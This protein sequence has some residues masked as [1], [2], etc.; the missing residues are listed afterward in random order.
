[1]R[2]CLFLLVLFH[3]LRAFG[4]G[5]NCGLASNVSPGTYTAMAITGSGASQPGATGSNWYRFTPTTNGNLSIN[6]CGGG[7][8]T[9]LWIWTGSCG[10]LTLI[11]A[12]D[13]FNGCISSGTNSFASRVDNLILSAG[14]TYFFEWDNAWS[15]TGFTWNFSYTALPNNND[16]GISYLKNRFTKI[17]ISQANY[18]IPLGATIKNY[19]GNILSNVT[20]TVEIYEFPNINTPVQTLTSTPITLGI[21]AEQA[22]VSGTWLPNL[23]VSKNYMLKY[24]KTQTQVDGV[25]SNDA[26]TQ[27]LS[28]DFNSFARDN[29][30]YTNAFN[31]ST[32]SEYSQGVIFPLT[33][34]DVL[35]GIQFYTP[36]TSS[37]QEYYVEVFPVLNNIIQTN[38]IYVSQNILSTG[39]GWQTHV[40]STPLTLTSGIYLF[41]IH[42]TGN[43]P[44]P[45]GCDASIF[46]NGKN[47]VR[48]NISGTW[49]TI[50]SYS[51]NYAFMIRPKLGASPSIDVSYVNHQSPGAGL[52][53]VHTRQSVNGNNLVLTAFGKNSGTNNAYNVTMTVT[54]KNLATNNTIYTA[55]SAGHNLIA[56]QIDTF[57]VSN[58]T[59]HS[60]GNYSIEYV[61]NT[62]NDQIPLNNSYLTYFSRTKSELSRVVGNSGT[63]G[64]GNNLTS[65]YDNG[66]IGQN[67]TLGQSDYLDS[68]KIN[69]GA[70]TPSNQPIRVDIYATDVNG[71][72]TG[73]PLISTT[74]YTST[75][76]NNISG[77]TIQ[78]P[79]SGGTY[80]LNPGTY[81]FGVTENAGNIK[82]QT[83][84]TYFAANSA[85]MRWNQNP[86]GATAWTAI[87]NFGYQ[88]A[89]AIQPIFKT[90][91]PIQ[92][93]SIVTNASCGQN[94][95]S[96]Q[97]TAT[98]GT[99]LFTFNWSN[100]STNNGLINNLGPGNY[101]CQLYDANFCPVAQQNATITMTSTAVNT[102]VSTLINPICNGV[103]S[104]SIGIFASGGNGQ[105]SYAWTPNIGTTAN[106][107]NLSA[108]SYS[109]QVTDGL[110][111][112]STQQIILSQP[113]AINVQSTL[114]PISCFGGNNGSIILSPTGGTTP[115][116]FQWTSGLG[117]TN[118]VSNLN[119]GVYSC[120]ITDGNGCSLIQNVTISNPPAIT[121]TL[122]NVS[123]VACFGTSSGSAAI[124][125]A[126]GTG[127]LSFI[128]SPNS[129]TGSSINNVPAGT[130]S[131][132]ISDGNGCQHSTSLNI[133]QPSALSSVISSTNSVSCFGGTN[134]T[135]QVIGMGGTAPYSYSWSPS[136]GNTNF[137][138]NLSAGNYQCQVTDAN[139]CST[140][141]LVQ[142]TS[143]SALSVG[144][145]S[146]SP[147]TCGLN[148]GSAVVTASGGVGPYLYNWT[149]AVGT[150]SNLTNLFAGSYQVHVIDQ[151]G[152][153]SSLSIGINTISGPSV[154][155]VSQTPVSCY[156][157]ANGSALISATGGTGTLTYNWSGNPT[158]N[159]TNF[160]SNLT[161]AQYTCQVTDVNGCVGT[162]VV[163]ITQPTAV[164][165]SISSNTSVTCNGL[166]TG[167]MS[168]TAYGGTPGY[169]YSWSP[170][171]GN[172]NQLTNVPAGIYTCQIT[173]Q[174]GC[175]GSISGVISQPNNMQLF[176]DTTIS[177]S[178][179]SSTNGMISVHATGGN[180]LYSYV[181]S[182]NNSNS[183]TLIQLPMGS[184]LVTA[185]DIL[186]CSVSQSIILQSQ[187][188][189]QVQG[190]SVQ[191]NCFGNANGQI[192]LYP[193]N[194]IAP[195][196]FNWSN[197]ATTSVINDLSDGIYSCT[198]SDA[199]GCTTVYLDTITALSNLTAQG[200]GTNIVCDSASTGSIHVTAANGFPPYSYAWSNSTETS[201]TLQT[202]GPGNFEVIVTDGQNCHDTIS[203][204]INLSDL[205]ATSQ[206]VSIACPGGLTGN[207][208]VSA[209]GG[210]VP[211]LY[212]WS[213]FSWNDS[214]VSGIGAGNYSCT[215][216]DQMG[217]AYTLQNTVYEPFPWNINAVIEPEI[218]GLD[219]SIMLGVSGANPPYNYSWNNG[220]TGNVLSQIAGGTYI[221]T[222]TD[223]QGCQSIDS[224]VV[225]SQLSIS[226][227]SSGKWNIY[228]NPNNGHFIVPIESGCEFSIFD[229][230]GRIISFDINETTQ[231]NPEIQ[232]IQA[233][234]GIYYLRISGQNWRNEV[235]RF[236][237]IE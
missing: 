128:W 235:L 213:G 59:I 143:P 214:I 38:P 26:S 46:S 211:Y 90:C 139:G 60:L 4:Q 83:S 207:I 73:S 22:I 152:C 155:L 9:R 117:N 81:F 86:N 85:F 168:V 237:V 57:S 109:C 167:Q 47:Y 150:T 80:T 226:E 127:N 159:G 175:Q 34:N 114:N 138:T 3:M 160:I 198:V 216:S 118:S 37:T 146:I 135:A 178:C 62:V 54:I 100:N 33:G 229:S 19:S 220:Q 99:G 23:S 44:Y 202:L 172:T 176:V 93:S 96:V 116:Q 218:F 25:T 40:L 1:M 88:V 16:S 95:G 122:L 234:P 51:V 82:L 183:N 77:A 210:Q 17:P 208:H 123:N 228:P 2:Y 107:N 106:V 181:W 141:Q 233:V 179:S 174:H 108:G 125:A 142:I 186:G 206:I 182:P 84:S 58:Y 184:Y 157:G 52:S 201:N 27:N 190:N 87:E 78:L 230:Y 158:G 147:A 7:S 124:S 217:C 31:W 171:G 36:S 29:D 227:I 193:S 196:Q 187:S 188:N 53:K 195:Y 177:P 56:G 97:L 194:G 13:D 151:H 205:H 197:L 55:T 41:S 215:I 89:L 173:D 120:Q 32:T 121:S 70:G 64:I 76:A 126:G 45:I 156:N 232:L 130:Y 102:S 75:I 67:F 12:N 104:G 48:T 131:C 49:N 63:I 169:T 212:Q 79:I 236:E 15:S 91:L 115:Y 112:S 154:T 72:P 140:N 129:I 224:L 43:L 222:I 145:S 219:G 136:G 105:Y 191:N 61:F 113:S 98:G 21:G 165:A 68:V 199:L 5:A 144:T 65:A 94:N 200:T 192:H 185:T 66:I 204:Q 119:A 223:A 180:G 71:V 137:A 189:L 133:T 14:N 161:A 74:T 209:Q 170:V 18:G 163:P 8:D 10:N 103:A 166:A 20:L 153:S 110:G 24:I 148:N 6:S 35:T 221:V 69:L 28:I 134:G 225:N 92:V 111:C 164:G 50:E 149:P 203:F 162:I 30:T 231:K 11:G 39:A 101:S 42:K 132:T